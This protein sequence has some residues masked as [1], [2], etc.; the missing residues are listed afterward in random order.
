MLPNIHYGL[1]HI[2]RSDRV[3]LAAKGCNIYLTNMAQG[4]R[5]AIAAFVGDDLAKLG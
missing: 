1:L 3:H 4:F 5:A 2:F